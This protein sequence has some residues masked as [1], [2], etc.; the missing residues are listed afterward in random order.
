MR[1]NLHPALSAVLNLSIGL[2]STLPVGADGIPVSQ[3]RKSL[4]VEQIT[5]RL[6][7]AQVRQVERRRELS[8][9]AEQRGPL[10]ARFGKLPA[11]LPAVSSRYDSCTCDMPLYAVWCRLGEVEI[12]IDC[13]ADF[14]ELTAQAN[15]PEEEEQN[16][17]SDNFECLNLILD[18]AGQ[19]YREGKAMDI[20][21][22]EAEIEA[23]YQRQ[24]LNE[25]LSCSVFLDTPPPMDEA[26]DDR[27][28]EVVDAVAALCRTRFITMWAPGY[29]GEE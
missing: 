13:L 19:Y 22:I 21:D 8:L 12:P 7:P 1:A 25:Q 26:T 11:T 18:S 14:K 28:H 6:T 15:A 5:I 29:G 10:H 16:S 17:P 9:T 4:S 2:F 24:K 3:D 23:M 20:T 27:I